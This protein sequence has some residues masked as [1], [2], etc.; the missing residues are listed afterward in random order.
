MMCDKK[1]CL[2]CPLDHCIE[3]D[4]AADRYEVQHRYYIKHKEQ[5]IAYQHKYYE[6]HKEAIEKQ[7]KEYRARKQRERKEAKKDAANKA[8]ENNGRGKKAK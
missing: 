3:D 2:N 5:R 1:D 4:R 6:E 7:K 8:G